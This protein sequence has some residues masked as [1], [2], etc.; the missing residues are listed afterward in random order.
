MTRSTHGRHFSIDAVR[1]R[2]AEF[3]NSSCQD[4]IDVR[5][6]PGRKPEAVIRQRCKDGRTAILKGPRGNSDAKI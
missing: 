3:D 6:Q 2:M 5:A 4:Y 1:A